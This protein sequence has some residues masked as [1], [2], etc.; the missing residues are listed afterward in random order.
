MEIYKRKG[1]KDKEKMYSDMINLEEE[2]ISD[3]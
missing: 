1:L 2:E 3:I